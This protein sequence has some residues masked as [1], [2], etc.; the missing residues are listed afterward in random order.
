[1]ELILVN[2]EEL[3]EIISEMIQGLSLSKNKEPESIVKAKE[4]LSLDEAVELL[5]SKGLPL[6]KNYF[7]VLSCR[8]EVPSIKF[9]GR[10]IV[11]DAEELNLWAE[12]RLKRGSDAN[13][14][15]IAVAKDARS[16]KL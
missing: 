3:R 15:T 10:K 11:F 7:Y 13:P 1:M 8:K 6:S 4:Y 12:S 9:G 16:K 2:K 14:V 5:K